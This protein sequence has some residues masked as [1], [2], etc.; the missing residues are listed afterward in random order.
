MHR[1]R[2]RVSN[3][4]VNFRLAVLQH[5]GRAV[6]GPELATKHGLEVLVHAIRP[7]NE[8]GRAFEFVAAVSTVKG[9]QFWKRL[10]G[11]QVWTE[12]QVLTHAL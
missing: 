6:R 1:I 12:L 7:S 3:K 10:V 5:L 4:S 2:K 11:I 9:W 8:N